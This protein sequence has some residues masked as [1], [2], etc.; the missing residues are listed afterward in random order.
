MSTLV[1]IV[2]VGIGRQH[3]E[4]RACVRHLLK[5]PV[6][7]VIR[8]A[9]TKVPMLAAKASCAALTASSCPHCGSGLAQVS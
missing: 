6:R 3:L 4:L 1:E 8:D 9:M 2:E 7:R 5:L